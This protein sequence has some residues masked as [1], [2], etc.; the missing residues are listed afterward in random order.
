MIAQAKRDG[1]AVVVATHHV[2][3]PEGTVDAGVVLD[4]GR[5]TAAGPLG[6]VL[7][8]QAAARLGLTAA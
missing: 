6:Q 1:A 7:D 4:E 3:F 5:V 8:S 2:D